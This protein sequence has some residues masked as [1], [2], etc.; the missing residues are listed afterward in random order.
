[1]WCLQ[2]FDRRSEQLVQEMGLV[3]IG[4][5]DIRRI[6]NIRDDLPVE[7]FGFDILSPEVAQQFAEFSGEPIVVDPD[8]WYQLG[9]YSD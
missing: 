9:F 7:P 2:G 5:A 1:M 3:R 4:V 6:L 8:L